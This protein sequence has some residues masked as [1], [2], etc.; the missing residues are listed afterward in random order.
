L[1]DKPLGIL[2]AHMDMVV[3]VANGKE[4][5]KLSDPITAIRNDEE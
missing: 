1:E 4:F 5:D 3:A 2:Q